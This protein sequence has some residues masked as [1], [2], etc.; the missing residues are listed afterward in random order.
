M[1]EKPNPASV[2][3]M[4]ERAII[5]ITDYVNTHPDIVIS[6]FEPIITRAYEEAHTMGWDAAIKSCGDQLQQL[7]EQLET[8]E[9]RRAATQVELD[10]ADKVIANLKSQLQNEKERR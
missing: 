8:I 9:N 1:S 2:A 10:G 5:R 4:V 3:E 7:R 6:N